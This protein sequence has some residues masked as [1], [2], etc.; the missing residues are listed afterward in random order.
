MQSS[1]SNAF[2]PAPSVTAPI[3]DMRP[4]AGGADETAEHWPGPPMPRLSTV[5]VGHCGYFTEWQQA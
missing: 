2:P 5:L 1:R 3:F 4:S